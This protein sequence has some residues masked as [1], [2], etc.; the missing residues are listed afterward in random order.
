MKEATISRRLIF[1][2]TLPGHQGLM[3]PSVS[4]LP[5][6]LMTDSMSFP[7]AVWGQKSALAPRKA[8]IKAERVEAS[9]WSGEF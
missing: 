8:L 3:W 1:T 4:W 7:L 6:S 2:L 5:A 9:L